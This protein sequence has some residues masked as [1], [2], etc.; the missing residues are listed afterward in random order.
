MR[1]LRCVCTGSGRGPS[2]LLRPVRP[3]A[4]RAGERRN[5]G[6]GRRDR[7]RIQRHGSGGASLRRASPSRAARPHWDRPHSLLDH[8]IHGMGERPAGVPPGGSH[9][10]GFGAQRQPH[11]YSRPRGAAR[12]SS[13]H[14]G[15]DAHAGGDRPGSA[16]RALR[17]QGTRAGTARGSAYVLRSLHIGGDGSGEL[18][19]GPRPPWLPAVVPR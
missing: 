15:L 19:G 4:P 7:D 3:A 18:G 17:R 6:V 13:R 1:C 5:R 16:G 2:Q 14:L 12:R 8:G 11:Q 9:R 10:R